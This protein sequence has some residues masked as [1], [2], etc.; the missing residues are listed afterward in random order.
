LAFK[1][2]VGDRPTY[3]FREVF[4]GAL[5][6]GGQTQPVATNLNGAEV[7]QVTAVDPDGSATIDDQLVDVTGTSNGHALP[8]LGTQHST[9]RVATDG[10][11]LSGDPSGGSEAKVALPA[12]DQIYAILPPKPVQPGATWTVDFERPNPFGAGAWKVHSENRLLR[13]EQM[14]GVRSAVVAS[15]LSTPFDVDLDP[16]RLGQPAG[17]ALRESGTVTADV[18]TWIDPAAGRMVRTSS[19]SKFDVA[20]AVNGT[21][22]YRLT[23]S[24]TVDLGLQ[25]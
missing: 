25:S 11:I 13:Y 8:P 10:R 23:G 14:G 18:T 24:Q 7:L 1:F 19:K 2:K 22:S 4:T 20:V 17:V 12:A 15:R 21:P 3:S 5:L 16:A 6:T 9:V